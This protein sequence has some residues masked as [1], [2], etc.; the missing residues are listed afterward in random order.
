MSPGD[1]IVRL[2]PWTVAVAVTLS[3]LGMMLVI[4]S[5]LTSGLFLPGVVLIVVGVLKFAGAAVFSAL[6]YLD[7]STD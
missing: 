3:V 2:A 5:V 7:P 6:G 1:L 4:A